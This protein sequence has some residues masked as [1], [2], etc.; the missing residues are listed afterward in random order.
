MTMPLGQ[1]QPLSYLLVVCVVLCLDCE[2]RA[3]NLN[4]EGCSLYF[5]NLICVLLGEIDPVNSE[6]PETIQ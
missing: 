6:Q 3:M 2:F 4:V 1:I 5:Y